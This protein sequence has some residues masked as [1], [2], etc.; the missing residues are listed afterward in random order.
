MNLSEFLASLSDEERKFISG[1]DY[2]DRQDEHR[3]ALDRVIE[4]NGDLD[5]EAELW[6]PYEV[7]ELGKNWLQDSHEREFVACAAIVLH[8]LIR[9]VDKMNDVEISMSV[10]LEFFDQL[11]IEH[12]E[13]LEPLLTQAMDID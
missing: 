5:M 3:I 10:V 11:K 12:Q 6:C 1:L 2:H 9:G 8:N 13:L 7:I 4:R